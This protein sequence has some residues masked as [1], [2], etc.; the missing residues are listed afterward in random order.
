[1]A[2][3]TGT[4]KGTMMTRKKLTSEQKEMIYRELVRDPM[5]HDL[6]IALSL[7]V[8]AT[9]VSHYRRRYGYPNYSMAQGR[10]D[11]IKADLL[12]DP[13][14][15][16]SVI[17]LKHH[18]D[19]STVRKY[20]TELGLPKPPK[21]ARIPILRPVG[22]KALQIRAILLEQPNLSDRCIA[23][24]TDVSSTH[25]VRQRDALGIP[26]STNRSPSAKSRFDYTE[27]DKE[28][29]AKNYSF[30]A[31][32]AR[33]NIL[34][35]WITARAKAIGYVR[36]SQNETITKTVLDLV[37]QP[38][39]MTDKQIG[40]MLGVSPNHVRRIRLNA[41]I[42]R[43]DPGRPKYDERLRAQALLSESN[44]KSLEMIAR[45]TGLTVTTVAKERDKMAGTFKPPR[46]KP[47][48]LPRSY[49]A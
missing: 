34:P 32:A 47:K 11:A 19:T 40:I 7:G 10:R 16:N 38:K 2:S 33:H 25:V 1:M 3:Y 46:R 14:I 27:V 37:N 20:R 26:R 4:K 49:C 48:M 30:K 41:G 13:T 15:S 8:K 9:S 12:A 17:A 28:I 36:N 43:L 35:A 39:R 22:E 6:D 5:R 23:K 31:I 42:P 18:C 24:L 29:W 21:S 45:E 44:P